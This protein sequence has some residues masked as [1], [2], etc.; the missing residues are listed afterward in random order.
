MTVPCHYAKTGEVNGNLTGLL[1]AKGITAP[2]DVGAD[3]APTIYVHGQPARTVPAVRALARATATLTGDNLVS[4]QP[5]HLTNYLADPVELKVLHMVTGDPKRTPSLVMFGNPNFWLTS[6]PANCGKSCFTVPQGTDAWNHGTV[7][8]Q[9]NTTWIGMVGP[10]VAHHGVDNSVWSDHTDAQPTMM[11]L[12]GL[13]DDYAPYGRVLGE[14]MDPAA[15]PAGMRAHRGTL[16]RLGRVYTQL[17]APVGA[18]GLDT[19]R[20]S[21]RALASASPGDVTYIRIENAL[22]RLGA[23]RDTVGGQMRAMLLGAAFAGRPLDVRAARAL[24]R[25]GDRL[26][27]QA[28]VLGARSA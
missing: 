22:Q 28:A 5:G 27:G 25:R 4:G 3:S 14:I 15:L 19:L 10:G 7:A 2:F 20:A 13:R 9:I 6:G 11:A 1:A 23:A 17:E 16:L 21:T 12:L 8:G 26:L 24:I 18:F